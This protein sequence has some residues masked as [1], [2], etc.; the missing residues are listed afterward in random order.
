[1]PTHAPCLR[2]H[3][4]IS[5]VFMAVR[6]LHAQSSTR[7]ISVSP[8]GRRSSEERGLG[9]CWARVAARVARVAARVAATRGC[10]GAYTL[11]MGVIPNVPVCRVHALPVALL[12]FAPH[13]SLTQNIGRPLVQGKAWGRGAVWEKGRARKPGN[14][15]PPF[16]LRDWPAASWCVH[17][18]SCAVGRRQEGAAALALHA[19]AAAGD[20]RGQAGAA[21]APGLP[22]GPPC[23]KGC[24]RRGP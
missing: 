17:P 15:S 18:A 6:N 3:H 14:Y 7:D 23:A 11:G 2:Q 24:G 16:V 1:L 4:H 22:H 5:I 13:A 12:A 21:M 20:C 10:R 9:T 8:V 19:V